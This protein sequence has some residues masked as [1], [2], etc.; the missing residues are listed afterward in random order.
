M[1][2]VYELISGA[3]S[4]SGVPR[5][6]GLQRT[7]IWGG[8]LL[9]PLF[10]AAGFLDD[11]AIVFRRMRKGLVG[12]Q[13]LL[14][15][16]AIAAAYLAAV[17]LAGDRGEG[18]TT[19]PFAGE[20]RLGF[21]YYPLSLVLIL[22]VVRGAELAQEADGVMP[23][24]GFFS[25]MP[26]IVAAGFLSGYNAGIYDAGIMA[27]AASGGCLAFLSYNF[28]PA[29]ART[30]TAGGAFMGALLCG[31]AFATR[32]PVLLVLS[33]AAYIA[34]SATALFAWLTEKLTG[35][36][37]GAPLH[38]MIGRRDKNDYQIT[39]IFAAITSVLGAAGAALA[40]F[41]R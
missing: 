23:T 20:V 24:V 8:L 10:G 36:T 25:F 31:A 2:L 34:E 39:V 33:G 14:I 29:Q 38:R 7:Y 13:R 27:V 35:K 41:G 22:A 18:I 40:I 21:W 6:S 4:L 11:Y 17:W 16:A 37:V 1:L 32:M 5:L 28:T 3:D 19:I 15:Q 9:G 12:W 26:I 30:G